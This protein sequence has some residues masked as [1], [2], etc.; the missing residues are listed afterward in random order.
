VE[1]FEAATKTAKEKGISPQ[2]VCFWN[3]V[4]F[5]AIAKA[6]YTAER[7]MSPSA[8][9]PIARLESAMKIRGRA[10]TRFVLDRQ[11][12]VGEI[13]EVTGKPLAWSLV[14]SGAIGAP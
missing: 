1:A 13:V 4:E 8:V 11:Y 6:Q 14:G 7:K 12:E 10:K 9:E 5:D 3:E 2:D